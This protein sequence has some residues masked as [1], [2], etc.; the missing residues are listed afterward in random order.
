MANIDDAFTID[1]LS[2]DDNLLIT[3]GISDPTI[4]I[5]YEA[6]IGSLYARTNGVLYQKTNTADVDWTPLSTNLDNILNNTL[7]PTGITNRTDSNVSFIDATRTFA[8]APAISDFTYFIKG[9]EYTISTVKQIIIPDVTGLVYIYFDNNENLNILNSFTYDLLSIYAYCSAI[10]WNADT[11]QGIYVAD[12]RH[13]I[14]MDA[15]THLHLHTSFGTQY[16]SGL[17]TSNMIVD[18]DGSLDSH[19]QFDLSNGVIRDEDLQHDIIDNLPQSLTGIAQIPILYKFGINNDWRIKDSDNFPIIQNGSAGFIGTG[20]PAFNELI[21]ND[22]QLTEITNNKFF[23]VHY[24]ATNDINNP[25]I[26]ILGINQ[27]QNRPQGQEAASTEFNTLDGLPFQEYVPISTIIF[28]A[29]SVFTN[30]TKCR[31]VST[32]DG[33]DYIDWT[34][35]TNTFNLIGTGATSTNDELLKISSNDTTAGYLTNKLLV[36]SSLTLIENN[37]GLNETL[38]IDTTIPLSDIQTEIDNIEIASGGIFASD[39]TYDG[40][41]VDALLSNVATSTDLLNT[42][43]QLDTA[44]SASPNVLTD[45]ND[46]TLITP[47]DGQT[48]VYDIATSQWINITTTATEPGSGRL[49]QVKFNKIPAL[50]GTIL[51]PINAT[52]P[53]ITEGVELWNEIVTP[54]LIT[55]NIRI[56]TT[57]TVSGSSNSTQM[58]FIFFRNNICIGTGL[59]NMSAR[60]AGHPFAITIYDSP[61]TISPITYSC[62]VGKT[63][64]NTWYINRLS[65]ATSLN[66]QLANQ[67]Y[68]I[69]EIGVI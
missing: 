56:S 55:S 16:L 10:Y 3:S 57:C 29:K 4:G 32:S 24:L 58:I 69:E 25:I 8:I 51:V 42:L 5:G 1:K 59:V 64:G 47:A 14:T 15:A 13:G 53:L 31:I 39:G 17:N 43:G 63:S 21:G 52:D 36:G 2:L 49:L 40:L 20:L 22:W 50:S 6:P 35:P 27:Y 44:I 18:D 41:T 12:E 65:D 34:S 38:T 7:E 23:F 61:N 33:F 11:Q 19:M 30:T 48:L 66:G 28:E 26:G 67:A 9:I 46:V 68:T 45:L 37:D 62:R 60:T 54:A